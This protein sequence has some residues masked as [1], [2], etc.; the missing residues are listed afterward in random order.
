MSKPKVA[1]YWNASCGGCEEAVFDLA[2]DIF[3]VVEA[4]DIVFWPV[5]LDFKR[6][7]V[8]NMEDGEITVSFING[9]IRTAEQEDMVKLLR[10]RSQLVVAFGSCAHIGGIPGLANFNSRKQIF[11]WVYDQAPSV[12]NDEKVMPGTVTSVLE[13]ELSLPEFY[14]TVRT[15]DMVIDVDYYL[16]GCAPPPDLI[17]EAI[18]AILEGKLPEKGAVLAPDK[19]L[20]DTCGR[21]DNKPENIR[22]KEFKRVHLTEIDPEKCFLEQGLIC[23]GPV[24]RSG[25]GERCINANMPCRGCFGAPS[26]VIDQGA[27]LLSALASMIDAEEEEEISRIA[28]TL[29]DPAGMLNFY[30]LPSSLLVRKRGVIEKDKDI[31]E[32]KTEILMEKTEVLKR[33]MV[34]MADDGLPEEDRKKIEDVES[35]LNEIHDEITGKEA[36]IEKIEASIKDLIN[37][38]ENKGMVLPDD[39]SRE[40]ALNTEEHLRTIHEQIK[41]REKEIA[42]MEQ[43]IKDLSSKIFGESQD[44]MEV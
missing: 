39:E 43:T 18:T 30:S 27:K 35:H 13:G 28:D 14:N 17:M 6:R 41:E 5:A 15:L 1:F 32:E 36:E 23:H 40:A 44:E 33:E 7:D 4:V 24:T 16:P 29:V 10:S 37:R 34:T 20:C 42:D 9:A 22:L 11:D 38:I 25:C 8:E 31:P 2:E 21:K 26:E 12:V 19:C 3:T